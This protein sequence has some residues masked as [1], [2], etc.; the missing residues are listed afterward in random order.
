MFLDA[1]SHGQSLRPVVEETDR[2]IETGVRFSFV[3]LFIPY[4]LCSFDKLSA[5]EAEHQGCL[6]DAGISD[7]DDLDV[8]LALRHASEFA[9]ALV[10]GR[11]EGGKGRA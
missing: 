8:A 2:H 9:N 10:G 1:E 5:F 11:E 4:R 7:N 6:A 3:R